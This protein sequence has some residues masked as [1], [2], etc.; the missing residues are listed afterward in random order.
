V[1][2]GR[3]TPGRRVFLRRLGAS[4]AASAAVPA[5]TRAGGVAPAAPRSEGTLDPAAPVP[6]S[7]ASEEAGLGVAQGEWPLPEQG[8]R[9]DLSPARWIWLPS[10]RTLANTV[11]LFR[12]EVQIAAAPVSARGFV[13]ADS[14]YRLWVNGQRVQWGPAPCDPRRYEVDPLDLTSALEP[15]ANVIAAEVLFYGH[16]EGTWPLG[17]PGFLFAL[18][19]EDGAGTVQQ[20]VSDESWR[21]LLDRAHTPGQYKRWYLRS[22]QEEMDA[23]ERPEGWNEPGLV[24]GEEWLAPLVLGGGAD[25]PAAASPYY[26]Y[27][28]DGGVDAGSSLLVAREVPLVRE[29]ARPVL[30][31]AQSGR[32]RW[33]RDPDDWFEYRI[34]GSFELV[35]G[36]VAFPSGDGAW[37]L[38]PRRGEGVWALFELAEQVVGFVFFSVEAPA[39]TIVELMTQESHSGDNPPW[40]D[41]H[42]HSWSRFVCREGENRFETFDYESLRFLQIHVREAAGP[43]QVRDV[44]VR[45]RSYDW[46]LP[47]N[48]HCDEPPLQRLF[49]AAFN[50]LVNAAQETVVDGMGRER[51][52]YSGD[53]SHML[54]A[55]RLV[56][57]DWDLARRFQHTFALGQTHEGYFLDCWPAWDRLNR[58]AQ[59]EVGATR[60]GP[61]LDHGVSFI[62][63]VWGHY[64]ETSQDDIARELY[65]RLARFARFLLDGLGSDGLLPVEG[66]G[67]PAVW[68]DGADCF[69]RQ[70]HKQCA[71]NLFT[72]GVLSRALVPL[73]ELVEEASDARS[74]QAA[75]DALEKATVRHFWSTK[76]GLF[77]SNLPWLTEEG[78]DVRLDDRSL[79]TALLF[80]Q[81]PRGETENVVAALAEP[82]AELGLS[83]PAN[84]H[85]RLQALAYHGRIDVVLRELR[86]RWA[87]LPSVVENNTIAEHWEHRPDTTDQWSHAAVSPLF[88]LF[89][90]IAGLRP[91][92]PG[93]RKVNVRPQLGDLP[94]LELTLPTGLGPIVFRSQ[95]EG[96]GHKVYLT[97]PADMEGELRLPSEAPTELRRLGVIRSLGLSRYALPS[98]ETVTFDVPGA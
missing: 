3:G 26:E 4:V 66:W 76:R 37:T 22:L 38:D 32:I 84:A 90:D 47:P 36:A 11:V 5:A 17:K 27:L 31:L 73:A 19:I 44:G 1:S 85:W 46:P 25:R 9:V 28:T 45:R 58:I 94:A 10:E 65:P 54:H 82:S 6:G 86:Y 34:P 20:V 67:V 23:R 7:A 30:R 12:R 79:A 51:Q 33:R 95:P 83:F 21:V 35:E 89:M 77:V 71:F 40:L 14:R 41:T 15:G 61:L 18:R 52:Q 87:A 70:R 8:S 48:F 72:A 59:R 91:G 88:M 2:A 78:G 13:S 80:R 81:C 50:T 62:H 92:E 63:D 64:Q 55:T 93:F 42:F 68:M 96:Q 60:W 97:L 56:C 75:A 16:G 24:R 29:T 74:F 43:V 53:V 57:G 49:E 98:G 69:R 39:G